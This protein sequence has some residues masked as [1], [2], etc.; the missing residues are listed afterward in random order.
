MTLNTISRDVTVNLIEPSSSHGAFQ[1]IEVRDGH[2][3]PLKIS[4]KRTIRVP[5]NDQA[6]GLPPYYGNFPIYSVTAH[7][8]KFPEAL[9]QKGGV[10][11]PIYRMYF[12]FQN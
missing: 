2:G 12:P 8:E 10:F 11:I 3:Y 5:D 9:A 4:F 6:Y 7:A 1:E